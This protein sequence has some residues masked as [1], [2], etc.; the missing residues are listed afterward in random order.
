MP[1]L[2][3]RDFP[4]NLYE[5]LRA[6]AE[7]NHRSIAQQTVACVERELRRE[8]MHPSPAASTA[9]ATERGSVGESNAKSR[10]EGRDEVKRAHETNPSHQPD[11]FAIETY[12]V[13]AERRDHWEKLRKRFANMDKHWN[14]SKPTCDQVVRM[15]HTDRGDRASQVMDAIAMSET[16][17]GGV[18][19]CS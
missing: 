11:A 3:V 7:T 18:E 10:R 6:Y 17:A 15:I 5:E 16:S 1:A 2:Q 13:L 12:T 4:A 8:G 9:S 19:P 14:G